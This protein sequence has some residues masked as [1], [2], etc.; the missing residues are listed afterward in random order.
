M[1]VLPVQ[2]LGIESNEEVIQASIFEMDPA[3]D[4][5]LARAYTHLGSICQ[6]P[7]TGQTKSAWPLKARRLLLQSISSRS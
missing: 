5:G 7:S 4:D 6:G 1:Q 2:S 3:S